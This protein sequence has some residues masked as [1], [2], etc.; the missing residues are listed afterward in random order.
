[1]APLGGVSGALTAKMLPLMARLAPNRDEPW[2]GLIT[3]EPQ[4]N[5]QSTVGRLLVTRS[6][7]VLACFATSRSGHLTAAGA[8]LALRHDTVRRLVRLPEE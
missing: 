8:N 3:A 6:L 5:L 7:I 1:M 2:G 4:T